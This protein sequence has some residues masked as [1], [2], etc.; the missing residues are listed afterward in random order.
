M[1]TSKLHPDLLKAV[2]SILEEM[3]PIMIVTCGFR[4][5]VE[6][7]RLEEMNPIMRVTSGFRDP[8]EQE[9]LYDIGRTLPG[10]KVTNAVPWRSFHN[11]GLACDFCFQ[12][13]DPYPENE[14]L[15]I[16]FGMIVE[17]NGLVWGGNFKKIL[18][19]PHAQ[20]DVQLNYVLAKEKW[21][22]LTR[23]E[24][25]AWIDTLRGV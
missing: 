4:D 12:G 11:Y 18:D 5:P 3:N 1:D 9:R 14:N 7:E 10:K 2:N 21:Q 23:S 6:Q 24:F 19:R 22:T 25:F 8:V 16:T 13:Q 15:W 17:K 20:I